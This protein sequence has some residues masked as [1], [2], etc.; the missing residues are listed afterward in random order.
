MYK[1]AL[2]ISCWS[3][4]EYLQKIFVKV[5]L[6]SSFRFELVNI[7]AFTN[8]SSKQQRKEKERN[9]VSSKVIKS[10]L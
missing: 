4:G 7:L 5:S 9:V 6:Y 10:N 3:N 8:M 2:R 1:S